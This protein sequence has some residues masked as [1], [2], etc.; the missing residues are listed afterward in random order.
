MFVFV[1]TRMPQLQSACKRRGLGRIRH[2][3]V[4][5]LWIQDRLRSEDFELCK[6]AGN[7]NPAYILTKHVDWGILS[8]H[9]NNLHMI[10]ED[11]RAASAAHI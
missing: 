5:Y 2:L 6:I 11:G 1:S 10:F 8:K 4:A 7:N 3:A 9:L